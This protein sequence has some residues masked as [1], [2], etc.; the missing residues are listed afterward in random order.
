MATASKQARERDQ[1]TAD[2]VP[3]EFHVFQSNGGDYRWEVVAGNGAMLAQ[4]GAFA[5][6]DDAEQ[7]AGRVRDGAAST[8][9]EHRGAHASP[10]RA[11][12]IGKG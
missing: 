9:L 1:R 11:A 2:G 3:S 5:S 6:F 12:G 4:S 7:A 10:R 8:R